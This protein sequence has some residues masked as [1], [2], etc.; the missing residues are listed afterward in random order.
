MLL[1]TKVLSAQETIY[2]TNNYIEYQV[3]NLPIVLSVPHGGRLAP[4][5]IP[6]RTCNNAETVTD[7][8]T[9]ELAKSISNALYELT[10]CYP[11]IVICNLRRSKID[12]NRNIE[13]G[14]CGNEEAITAWKEFNSFIEQA[15]TKAQENF[16]GNIFLGELHGHAHD[17]RRGELG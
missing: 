7:I 12:C 11:S 13:D 4:S 5:T 8:N 6:D 10:G 2:G 14:A 9:I 1:Q 3:G 17:I 16:K 15:Q